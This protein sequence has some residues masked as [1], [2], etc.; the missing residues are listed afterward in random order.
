MKLSLH[1]SGIWRIAYLSDEHAARAGAA[2]KPEFD[3]DPRVVDRWQE[4]EGAAGWIHAFT[5]WVPYGHLTPL[6]DEV[7]NPKKPITWLAEPDEG[8]MVGIHFA[9]VRPDEGVFDATG[10]MLVDGFRLTNKRA[11]IVLT[12]RRPIEPERARWQRDWSIAALALKQGNHIAHFGDPLRVGL[13]TRDNDGSRAILDLRSPQREDLERV[14]RE[15]LT[16][17]MT[18]SSPSNDGT[19]EGL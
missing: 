7:E 11:L 10:M 12:S 17:N 13:F 6:P 15:G 19:L 3:N 5:V 16:V 9:V 4:P 2:G 1:Q 8:E 14:N 18:Y